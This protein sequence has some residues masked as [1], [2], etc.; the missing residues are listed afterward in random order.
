VRAARAL[1]FDSFAA[2]LGRSA[3]S[4]SN[5]ERKLERPRTARPPKAWHRSS[6]TRVG[7]LSARGTRRRHPFR[8]DH[9]RAPRSSVA[10]AHDTCT[11]AACARRCGGH[12]RWLLSHEST[13]R[14]ATQRGSSPRCVLFRCTAGWLSDR[15]RTEPGDSR[16]CW[17]GARSRGQRLAALR[18]VLF[19][20]PR[21]RGLTCFATAGREIEG[22]HCG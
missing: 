6:R 20:P 7:V 12:E 3:A 21:P 1:L 4:L 19:R 13:P 22:S 10:L 5:D 15:V 18:V 2:E 11:S 9:G 16:H 8:R 17:G 14:A